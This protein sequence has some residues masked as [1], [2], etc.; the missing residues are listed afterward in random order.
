MAKSRL[1]TLACLLILSPG[2][3]ATVFINEAYINPPGSSDNR[4]EFIE[5]LGTP[6]MKLDGYAVAVLN[7]TEQKFYPLHWAPTACW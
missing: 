4:R 6:G 3:Q 5:L 2:A 7:G 1:M